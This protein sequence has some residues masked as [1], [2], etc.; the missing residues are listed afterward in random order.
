MAGG[1]P[2]REDNEICPK[3]GNPGYS[4]S[5]PSWNSPYK[6]GPRNWYSRFIHRGRSPKDCYLGKRQ[7][8]LENATEYNRNTEEITT[9][10]FSP[11]EPKIKNVIN[12]VETIKA[13]PVMICSFS[14]VPN[15]LKPKIRKLRKL[16]KFRFSKDELDW[17]LEQNVY[18]D[19]E[20]L[21]RGDFVM[22]GEEANKECDVISDSAD[23]LGSIKHI[24]DRYGFFSEILQIREKNRR[25]KITRKNLGHK[26][27]H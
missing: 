25:I 22:F 2:K 4:Y 15:E 1:R 17:L 26:E 3:C 13:L 16:K 18:P 19:L 11:E 14:Y 24:K 21:S 27:P 6:N 20:H 23:W 8:P 5:V 10:N 12:R 9:F 7:L